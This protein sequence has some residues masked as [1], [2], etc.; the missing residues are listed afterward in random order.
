M[1]FVG[2]ISTHHLGKLEPNSLVYNDSN[3]KNRALINNNLN[4]H[5]S[6]NFQNEVMSNFV[7]RE[8]RQTRKI[9][10]RCQRQKK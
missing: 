2:I 9:R 5:F 4:T 10:G 3:H 7:F 6:Q 1:I 8:K